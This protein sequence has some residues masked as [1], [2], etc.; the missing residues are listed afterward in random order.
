MHIEAAA[1][2]FTPSESRPLAELCL[3]GLAKA[4]FA[5]ERALLAFAGPE[6]LTREHLDAW[7]RVGLLRRDN[8]ILDLARPDPS[9]YFALAREGAR[10]LGRRTLGH[11]VVPSAASWRRSAQTRGH[12]VLI[13]DFALA[14]LRLAREGS[15]HL[16]GIETDD[17]K[18]GTSV[19]L[20]EPSGE[21]RRVALQADAYVLT[22]GAGR[23]EGLLVE[24]DR[25][26]VSLR[27]MREKYAGYTCWSRTGGPLRDFAI[28]PL[29]VLT[30]TQNEHR[31]SELRRV[32]L[33]ANEGKRSGLLVFATTTELDVATPA[34]FLEPV[35]RVLGD[36]S[37]APIFSG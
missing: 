28:K 31:L 2:L 11:V 15:I 36:E 4:R 6:G 7:V 25:G 20:A 21:S 19:V 33:E 34:R 10:Q 9:P 23:K 18:F 29:R 17:S 27:R 22:R 1:P 37:R 13:G 14:V 26:T 5:S 35:A 8:V 3:L 32:A 12:D 24:V 30:L 16:E